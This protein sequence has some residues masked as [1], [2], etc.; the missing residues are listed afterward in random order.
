MEYNFVITHHSLVMSVFKDN[1]LSVIDS[2][3]LQT[4]KEERTKS[5]FK[6]VLNEWAD[7]WNSVRG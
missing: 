1:G 5:D 2:C 3:S 7:F 4:I 6:V